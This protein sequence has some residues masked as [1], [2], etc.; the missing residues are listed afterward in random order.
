[1]KI[2][3]MY[4]LSP[5]QKGMLF[6]CL[7]AQSADVYITQVMW[8]IR[9]DL[10]REALQQ[11]WQRAIERHA[12]LR[13]AFF[14]ENLDAPLQVVFGQVALPFEQHDWRGLPPQ[15][16]QARQEAARERDRARVA[17]ISKA[18]LMRLTLAR[19]ADDMHM[20]LWSR[21][22]LL[23]DG[24]SQAIVLREVFVLYEL[25]CWG[26]LG[27]TEDQLLGPVHP[28]ARYIAWL[29]QQD[30][31][32]A[33]PFFGR[34]LAGIEAPTPL[35]GAGDA[36]GGQPGEQVRHLPAERTAAL[37]ELARNNGLTLN[38]LVQAAWAALLAH[39]AGAADVVFGLTAS[40]RPTSLPGI[41]A[42][43]GLFINTLPIRVGLPPD[44]ALLPWLH[45]LQRLHTELRQ[46]EH[47]PLYEVQGWSRVPRQ[48]PLFE[49]VVVFENY[50]MDLD[51]LDQYSSLELKPV[52]S[53]IQNS[54]PLTL[55][56]VPGAKLGLHI[57][58]DGR[59]IDTAAAARVLDLVDAALAALVEHQHGGLADLLSA[60][61][62]AERRRQ[63]HSAQQ[64]K[65]A[66][67]QLLR[68][69]ARRPTRGVVAGEPG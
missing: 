67:A 3:T 5:L 33:A 39:D 56:A 15:E 32:A 51:Q 62:A 47:A 66:G 21:H 9:G 46:Y 52:E 37:Q 26:D 14:W 48:L 36:P 16:Q 6:H 42:M 64:S 59:R 61:A 20:L 28:F 7:R 43:V 25:Y 17:A 27:E 34:M 50:P 12:I 63:Q 13:T 68:G 4:E 24:W 1:M 18:P 10:N 57:L 65:Q 69:I 11:A 55:R 38:T 19:T 60:V 22:H 44:A 8:Q 35:R 2:E 31:Q 29:Q 49:S 54:L 45:D 41:E 23:L 58:H 53:H 40:G 30:L